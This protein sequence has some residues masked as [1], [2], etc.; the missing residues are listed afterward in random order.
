MKTLWL[1][2]CMTYA[3]TVLQADVWATWLFTFTG[4]G[5]A[6]LAIALGLGKAGHLPSHQSVG[7][8]VWYA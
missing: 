4:H 3:F 2:T 8:G 7:K 5:L 6:T 1:S